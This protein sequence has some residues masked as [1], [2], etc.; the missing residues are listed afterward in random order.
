MK[1][2]ALLI[3]LINNQIDE[4]KQK[5]GDLELQKRQFEELLG[6]LQ[7]ELIME[8]KLAEKSLELREVF[9]NYTKINITKQVGYR[10]NISA[11]KREIEMLQEELAELFSELKKFEIYQEKQAE[12]VKEEELKLEMKLLD[13]MALRYNQY[14][15]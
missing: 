5:I 7:A 2:I 3:K 12:E 13:E 9:S 6:Q 8:R 10:K 14:K 15:H 4:V 1:K 11:L